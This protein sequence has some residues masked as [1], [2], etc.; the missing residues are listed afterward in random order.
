MLNGRVTHGYASCLVLPLYDKDKLRV[1]LARRR[2]PLSNFFSRTFAL[3][4]VK[5]YLLYERNHWQ[6]LHKSKC[7]YALLGCRC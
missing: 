5:R 2:G 1:H 7:S 4:L 6:L 3:Q